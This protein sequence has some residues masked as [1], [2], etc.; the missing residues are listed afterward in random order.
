MADPV[1]EILLGGPPVSGCAARGHLEA[2][3]AGHFDLPVAG[4]GPEAVGYVVRQLKNRD[5]SH[6]MALPSRLN[7]NP[8]LTARSDLAATSVHPANQGS[9]RAVS[10]PGPSGR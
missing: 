3:R 7:E 8:R 2:N 1:R 5:R 6:P 9:G 10:P 4:D